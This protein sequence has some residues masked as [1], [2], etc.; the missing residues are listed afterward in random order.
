MT[1]S[2]KRLFVLASVALVLASSAYLGYA[3]WAWLHLPETIEVV[4]PDCDLQREACRAA[5]PGGGEL[6]L[7]L[8]PRPVVP[9]RPVALEVELVDLDTATVEAALD[10]PDM[11]MGY[12][13]QRLAPDGVARLRGHVVLPVC[14]L[15]QPMRWRLT[16]LARHSHTTYALPF[17]FETRSAEL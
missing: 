6:R 13:R 16:L 7:R 12:F 10:S 11:Y 4:P 3:V 5:L 1:F 17:V 2:L 15:K 14:T 8:S 9:L